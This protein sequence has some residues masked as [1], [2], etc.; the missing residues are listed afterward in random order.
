[1]AFVRRLFGVDTFNDEGK[2]LGTIEASNTARDCIAITIFDSVDGSRW[3]QILL[4]KDESQ[5]LI[6]NISLAWEVVESCSEG[7][8]DD[9]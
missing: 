5:A 6:A 9:E 3:E 4:S 1:M 2:Y 8:G 7:G